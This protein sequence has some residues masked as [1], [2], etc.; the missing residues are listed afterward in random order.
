MSDAEQVLLANLNEALRQVQW[1]VV[2]G[3]GTSISALALAVTG[4]ATDAAEPRV[5]VPG[6][7]VA[8]DPQ[9]ARVLLLAIC[10]LVGAMASYSAESANVIAVRLQKSS[11][12]LLDA[13]RTFPTIATSPYPGVRYA[14]AAL[15]LLFSLAAIVVATVRHKP[16]D[17]TGL[18]VGLIFLGAAYVSLALEL[19]RPIGAP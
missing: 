4:P 14:A 8:V 5:T 3:L 12:A 13:A 1:Y 18:W 11:P 2:L 9:T 10:V 19:R 15:P 6:T 7:F 16:S 17:W